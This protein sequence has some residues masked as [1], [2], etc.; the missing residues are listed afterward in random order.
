MIN[1][2]LN[3][4]FRVALPV[5]G[6]SL[7]T[8]GSFIRH[9]LDHA[10]PESA[11]NRGV[12]LRRASCPKI[13]SISNLF[14]VRDLRMQFGLM[15]ICRFVFCCRWMGE[16]TAELRALPEGR[17]SDSQVQDKDQADPVHR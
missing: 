8:L 17:G 15:Q 7:E 5:G 14:S 13:R 2:K 1:T 4:V 6:R 12:R 9:A 11:R 3:L 16:S 10:H